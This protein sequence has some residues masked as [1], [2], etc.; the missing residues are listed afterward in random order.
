M[1]DVDHINHI[2]FDIIAVES[3]CRST[4]VNS[5]SSNRFFITQAVEMGQMADMF[6][7]KSE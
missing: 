6:F 5:S 2:K 4:S 1:V 3:S 7:N